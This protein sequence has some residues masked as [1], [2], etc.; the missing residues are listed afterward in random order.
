MPQ[1]KVTIPTECTIFIEASDVK[2]ALWTLL[3]RYEDCRCFEYCD[4]D[5]QQEE[6][7]PLPM[8][9]ILI[10]SGSGRIQKVA[11]TYTE[12]VLNLENSKITKLPKRNLMGTTVRVASG[13]FTK[14]VNRF[15]ELSICP[16]CNALA[17]QCTCR[18]R[19]EPPWADRHALELPRPVPIGHPAP[20]PNVA[21]N[22]DTTAM[23]Q[24]VMGGA[25]PFTTRTFQA[26]VGTDRTE[27]APQFTREEIL[28]AVEAAQERVGEEQDQPEEEVE[29]E[30]IPLPIPTPE[31]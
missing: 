14:R 3:T 7:D 6:I 17:E 31:W 15:Q 13:R 28:G 21:A 30:P 4:D 19:N 27:A 16:S 1:Y 11:V 24:R 25:I 18:T 10:P 5:E 23:F 2:E 12:G 20:T 22:A 26:G 29:E 8:F 9:E